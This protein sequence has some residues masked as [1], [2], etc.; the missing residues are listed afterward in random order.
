[1]KC[2]NCGNVISYQKAPQLTDCVLCGFPLKPDISDILEFGK[3]DITTEKRPSQIAL[4]KDVENLLGGANGTLLAEGGT[5][6]GKSFAY[7]IPALLTS[8]KRII[9]STSKKSLQHQLVKEDIP[10]LIKKMGREDLSY[11]LYKGK[12]NYACWRLAP[13]VPNEDKQKFNLFISVAKNE[14]RPAD[15][16][17]WNG[18]LPS[19]WHKVSVENCVLT[20]SCPHWNYCRPKPRTSNLVITNHTLTAIDLHK[21]PGI[22]FGPYS[23]LIVDEAHQLGKAYQLAHEKHVSVKG[24]EILKSM[25]INDSNVSDTIDESGI[26]SAKLLSEHVDTLR[27]LFIPLYAKAKSTCDDTGTVRVPKIETELEKFREAII[28]LSSKIF[29]VSEAVNR[30]RINSAFS[31]IDVPEKLVVM[32]S[33][34]QKVNTRVENLLEF[35]NDILSPPETNTTRLKPSTGSHSQSNYITTVDD[36]G[37]NVQPLRIG[38][39]LGPKLKEI[40]FKILTSATL[41]VNKDFSHFK[42]EYGLDIGGDIVERSYS[43]PFDLERQAL[44]YLP[45]HLPLPQHEGSPQRAEWI[46]AIST[47]IAQLVGVTNGGAFVLFSATSDMNEVLE[48]MSA[49]W[50]NLNLNLMVQDRDGDTTTIKS[51]F[52]SEENSVVF[53]LKNFWEGIDIPGDKLRL[54]IIPKLPFPNIKDPIIAALK[55][56]AGDNWFYTVMIPRMFIDM[57]QGVGRLIRTTSDRGFIAILDPRIWTGSGT[58]HATNMRKINADPFK[59]RMGYGKELLDSLGFT[60]VTEDFTVLKKFVTKFFNRR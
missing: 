51:R 30:T 18:P 16:S 47:E 32:L 13:E 40:P 46:S 52:M 53:G 57:K 59:T 6:I 5:G 26:V 29:Q 34:I 38:A 31:D 25:I 43:S 14:N 49:V 45:Q 12:S 24:L 28:A 23:I 54:I 48:E 36:L 58:K 15:V 10:Y 35:T 19:W 39:L 50:D 11:T 3:F 60:T 2:T 1:M 44:M 7:L 4:A 37:I 9:L 33:R 20:T 27:E 42:K 21:N 55:K 17:E 8:N 56:E 41:A 22:L